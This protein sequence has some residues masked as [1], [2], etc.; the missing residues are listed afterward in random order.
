MPLFSCNNRTKTRARESGESLIAYLDRQ[1]RTEINEVRTRLETWFAAMPQ[2]EQVDLLPRLNSDDNYQ[3]HAAFWEIYCY[4]LFMSCGVQVE[5]H[6]SLPGTAKRPDFQLRD[7]DGQRMIVECR[8]ASES[9][10]ARAEDARIKS[11]E[12]MVRKM[13][14]PAFFIGMKI[15]SVGKQTPKLS[16]IRSFLDARIRELKPERLS[17][18]AKSHGLGSMPHWD[19]QDSEDGEGGWK[20]EFFPIP[21]SPALRGKAC[22]SNLGMVMHPFGFVQPETVFRNCLKAKATRYGELDCPY[23]VA[24]NTLDVFFDDTSTWNVL[25]GSEFMRIDRA[26]GE[27]T[28]GRKPNGFWFGPKGPLNQR[29][30]A[31]LL[32]DHVLPWSVA[33]KKPVLWHNPWAKNPLSTS[34]FPLSQIVPNESKTMMVPKDGRPWS[35]E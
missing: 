23:L 16:K 34:L 2:Q 12:Q 25:F 11:V 19:W 24:V 4:R 9:E 35:L 31:V 29:V 14:S 17:T 22:D 18:L 28:Q 20:L 30:S 6:P 10:A 13:S 3:F 8:L 32:G 7:R 27:A 21:K 15:R 5:V 26:T 1:A 33:E